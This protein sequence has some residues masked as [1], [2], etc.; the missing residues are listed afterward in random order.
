MGQ[1]AGIS[2]KKEKGKKREKGEG[3]E[4]EGKGRRREGKVAN[5]NSMTLFLPSSKVGRET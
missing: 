3:R 4:E 5:V 1:R 2:Q